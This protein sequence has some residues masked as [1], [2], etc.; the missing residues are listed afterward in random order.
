MVIYVFYAQDEGIRW[1]VT[2]SNNTI[3]NNLSFV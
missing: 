3:Q 2:Q 1:V